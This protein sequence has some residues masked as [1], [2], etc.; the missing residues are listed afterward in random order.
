MLP[1]FRSSSGALDCLYSLW[2]NAPTI[3]PA[4]SIVGTLY[5]KLQ[6]QSGAREVWRNYRPKYVELIEV[7]NKLF[8]LHLVGCL[9]YFNLSISEAGTMWLLCII[10]TLQVGRERHGCPIASR[11][12]RYLM[13]SVPLVYN[14]S[15]FFPRHQPPSLLVAAKPPIHWV[16][17]TSSLGAK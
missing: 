12:K 10:A 2:Y 5:H 14:A 15:D 9:Y 3:L 16:P 6:T 17:G 11:D 8:L 4:G 1:E 13:L 7:I